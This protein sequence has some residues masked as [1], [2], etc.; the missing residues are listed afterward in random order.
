MFFDQK[1]IVTCHKFIFSDSVRRMKV[2]WIIVGPS[3]SL[4][5]LAAI[6]DDAENLFIELESC[7][8]C[9]KMVRGVKVNFH[10]INI[11]S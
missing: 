10:R 9:Q 3:S 8:K 7:L 6:F 11:Y 1:V 2:V 5:L 4:R